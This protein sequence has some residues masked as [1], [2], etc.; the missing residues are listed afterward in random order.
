MRRAARRRQVPGLL[1]ATFLIEDPRTCYSVSV[2]DREPVFSA[3]V[4]EHIDAVNKVFA[5]LA[6]DE[7]RGPELWSTTWRLDGISHNQQWDDLD[8]ISR[9]GHDRL[10][11]APGLSTVV[12]N[13]GKEPC[14]LGGA[15]RD[16]P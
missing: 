2:W 1:K 11:P 9:V 10:R 3:F 4:Q 8:I 16:G 7:A 15:R 14:T 13:D 12:E 6:Y 5:H